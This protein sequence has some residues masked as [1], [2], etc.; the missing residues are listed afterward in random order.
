MSCVQGF[1]L[2]SFSVRLCMQTL[3]RLPMQSSVRRDLCQTG[4]TSS[5]MICPFLAFYLWKE[6]MS[7]PPSLFSLTASSGSEW[8]ES[9]P[10][11]GRRGGLSFIVC[12]LLDAYRE[13]GDVT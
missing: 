4:L 11:L 7:H 12:A 9:T 2:M 13:K 8:A 6:T 3:V 5:S 10:A 1:A